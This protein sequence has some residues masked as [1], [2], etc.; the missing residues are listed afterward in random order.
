MNDIAGLYDYRKGEMYSG[1]GNML[2]SFLYA[3]ALRQTTSLCVVS[4]YLETA[5]CILWLLKIVVIRVFIFGL[6]R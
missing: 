5:E 6:L 4:L 3:L 1:K 2:S